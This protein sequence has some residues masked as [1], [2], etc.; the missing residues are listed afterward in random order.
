MKSGAG[1]SGLSLQ[2][3]SS[4]SSSESEKNELQSDVDELDFVERALQAGSQRRRLQGD[5]R[6]GQ[7][8]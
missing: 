5:L 6:N 7:H 3:I 8:W 1:R 2:P 4:E